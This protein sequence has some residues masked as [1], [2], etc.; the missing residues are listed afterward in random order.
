MQNAYLNGEY[1][2][3]EQC[4]VSALDRGFI[5]GDGVYEMLPVYAGVVFRQQAHLDRLAR[6][7]DAI[8]IPNPHS[9]AE[10]EQI[11][12]AL[13]E[14]SG[15]GDQALYL[16][17]TRGCAPR[18]H[19]PDENLQPTVFGMTTPLT[20]LA[21]ADLERGIEAVT[22]ED[23][24]WTRCDVKTTS[25][26]ANV[27]LRKAAVDA[28]VKETILLRDGLLTEAAAANVFIV[29]VQGGVD[30][31]ATPVKDQRILAGVT[32]DLV[33]EL[34]RQHNVA[35]EERDV[36]EAELYAAEEIWL[37][38]STREIVPVAKLNGN[39]VGAGRAGDLWKQ[40]RQW[41][42]ETRS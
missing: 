1:M 38:S 12:R 5:F 23:I 20:A 24:R 15:G 42:L 11:I 6:S 26:I 8:G 21:L 30:T 18:D 32:R 7:C 37:T 14:K 33:I 3:V 27:L 19:Y 25:L 13:I 31:L 16:Q 9:D 22:R 35:I 40:F 10:W 28:D 4:R 17:I 39:A 36:R 34:A 29:L 41:V 2:P